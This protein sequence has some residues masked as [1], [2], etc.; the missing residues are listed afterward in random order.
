MQ[1][2]E[3]C[4]QVNTERGARYTGIDDRDSTVPR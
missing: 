4:T 3:D 1:C 2:L